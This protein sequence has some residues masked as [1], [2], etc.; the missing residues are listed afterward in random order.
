MEP[1]T[2][3]AEIDINRKSKASLWR[4]GLPKDAVPNYELAYIM[5]LSR[6]DRTGALAL[7]KKHQWN[8]EALFTELT[9]KNRSG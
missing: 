1:V 7:L 4:A 6:L 9:S 8:R 2:H 5:K 3:L